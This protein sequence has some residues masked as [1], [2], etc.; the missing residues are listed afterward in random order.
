MEHAVRE[1]NQVYDFLRG[2]HRYK[3]EVA[4]AMRHTVYV[5]A[6]RPALAAR[7]YRLQHIRW[8]VWK[9]RLRALRAKL[10]GRG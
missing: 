8:P 5:Q 7:A 3:D 1:G 10:K 9:G 4:S 6:Y 2:R